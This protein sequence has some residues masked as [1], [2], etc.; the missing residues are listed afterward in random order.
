MPGGENNRLN[1]QL[2]FYAP[3]I[4]TSLTLASRTLENCFKLAVEDNGN[5][6]GDSLT[7]FCVR[8][9]ISQGLNS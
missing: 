3:E 4:M 1:F 7:K 5:N 8:N 9:L 6:P 2:C